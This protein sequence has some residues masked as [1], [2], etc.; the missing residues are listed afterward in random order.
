MRFFQKN[1]IHTG[2][3]AKR[4]SSPRPRANKDLQDYQGIQGY[5]SYQIYQTIRSINAFKAN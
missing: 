1:E 3:K 2:N 5:Q 4:K